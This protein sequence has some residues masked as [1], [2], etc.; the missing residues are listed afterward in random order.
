MMTSTELLIYLIGE[1]LRLVFTR[2]AQEQ[3]ANL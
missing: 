2:I 3:K 1:I